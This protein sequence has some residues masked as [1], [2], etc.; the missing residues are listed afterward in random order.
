MVGPAAGLSEGAPVGHAGGRRSDR[1]RDGAGTQ[2]G[3]A[4]GAGRAA[5]GGTPDALPRTARATVPETCCITHFLIAPA[6]HWAGGRLLPERKDL[7]QARIR[8]DALSTA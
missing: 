3:G 7:G 1:V 8:I 5:R 2:L 6:S 4:P